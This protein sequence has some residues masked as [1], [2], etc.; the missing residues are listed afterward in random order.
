[1]RT[2]IK[3]LDVRFAA[4]EGQLRELISGMPEDKLFLKPAA[5]DRSLIDF[6]VGGCA[7]RSAAMIEQVFLGLTRRLWDD[8][9]E[10]TLP[11]KLNSPAAII[12]Y[13]GEVGEARVK[14]M[15]FLKSDADLSR[16]LPAPEKL[17][18]IFDVLV[19]AL[20]KAE[21]YHGRA[22]AICRIVTQRNG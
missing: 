9:F 12:D 6:S 8:P 19:E 18:P 20:V 11:E 17:R 10:W 14:G 1:M 22:E 16:E 15:V 5:D 2:L 21:H 13:L 7:V 4:L 3:S